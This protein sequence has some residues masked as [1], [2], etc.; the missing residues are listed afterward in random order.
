MASKCNKL[1]LAKA[2]NSCASIVFG[3][4]I[5]AKKFALW[6]TG[7]GGMACTLLQLGTSAC[8]GNPG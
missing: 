5:S 7:V 2:D 3:S 8:I 1:I 4:G 6:N